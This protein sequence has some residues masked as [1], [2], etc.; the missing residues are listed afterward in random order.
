MR[1][2]RYEKGRAR[3]E[4][5]MKGGVMVIQNKQKRG[6]RTEQG[7]YQY[8]WEDGECGIIIWE[9][10]TPQLLVI[11]GSV[12]GKIIFPPRREAV[13]QKNRIIHSTLVYWYPGLITTTR[14]PV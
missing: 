2:R 6:G 10:V 14:C 8:M 5:Q 7:W 11:D 1:K 9:F 13:S 3:N 4:E 12:F